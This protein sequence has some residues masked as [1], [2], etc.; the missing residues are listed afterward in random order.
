MLR[1]GDE[2]VAWIFV[3]ETYGHAHDSYSF[4][5]FDFEI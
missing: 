5:Q 1:R 3:V 2:G 4:D